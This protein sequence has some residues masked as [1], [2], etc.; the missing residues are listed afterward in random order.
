[1][2][3]KKV[4]KFLILLACCAMMLAF[5]SASVFA[6]EPIT[7]AEVT[8]IT[9]PEI[10]AYPDFSAAVPEN[11]KYSLGQRFVLGSIDDIFWFEMD[12][13]EK[14]QMLLMDESKFEKGKTYRL[15]IIL[16]A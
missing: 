10:G 12:G 15:E 1:M 6:A 3:S 11:A 13:E 8:G 16:E 5:G 2:K 7:T 9:V 14:G 4:S